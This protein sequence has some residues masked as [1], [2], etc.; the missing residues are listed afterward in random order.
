[1]NFRLWLLS[2]ALVASAAKFDIDTPSKIVRVSDPQ[3]S[4]DGK[5][6]AVIVSRANLEE[7]RSDSEIVLI[8]VA[9]KAQR[10]LTQGRRGLAQPR[11]TPSGD[12]LGFLATVDAK[13]QLFVLPLAGGE[14]QQVTHAPNGLQQYSFSRRSPL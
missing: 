11:W 7:N 9:T 3:L 12:G 5:S 6:I 10:V 2:A 14:A 1:M 13:P 4:P 8:D